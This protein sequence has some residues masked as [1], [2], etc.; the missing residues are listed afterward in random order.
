MTGNYHMGLLYMVHLL[1]SSDGH[2]DSQELEA[3]QRVKT[4]ENIPDELFNRFEEDVQTK[5]P[6]DIYEEAIEQLNQCSDEEKLRAFVILYKMSE[7]DGRVHVKEVR[8][9][10][11]SI[12]G[13]KIDFDEVARQAEKLP[14]Y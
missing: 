8:L 7:V 1:I 2:I 11:Y 10:L 3:L 13:A 9:L 6:H 5:K 12:K 14:A 4:R